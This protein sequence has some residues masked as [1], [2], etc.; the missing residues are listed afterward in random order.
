MK[1][2]LLFTGVIHYPFGGWN[3]FH[4]SY[5]DLHEAEVVG[6]EASEHGGWFHVIDTNN[7]SRV[8]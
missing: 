3:D 7:W 2:Y 5:D 6:M 1:R 8:I 4:S